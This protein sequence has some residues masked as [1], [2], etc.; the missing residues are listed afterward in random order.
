MKNALVMLRGQPF[1][2]GCDVGGS[3]W[4]TRSLSTTLDNVV[5]P[6]CKSYFPVDVISLPTVLC[7]NETLQRALRD[8]TRRKLDALGGRE[9]GFEPAPHANQAASMLAVAKK[10]M[11]HAAEY[12][13]FVVLRFDVRV[14]T[15]LTR[16]RCRLA[17]AVCFSDGCGNPN[18]PG[19]VNE[20]WLTVPARHAARVG[21]LILAGAK[22]WDGRATC[23]TA[24]P[25]CFANA[26][27]ERERG[28]PPP[29]PY[30]FSGHA[31]F[32]ELRRM[33]PGGADEA[34][35]ELGT[36][37]PPPPK[38]AHMSYGWSSHYQMFRSKGRRVR[39]A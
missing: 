1:R 22:G 9:I 17:D 29:S 39:V 35:L 13:V 11:L 38:S 28:E 24:R 26:E 8:A 2:V 36:C 7:A 5:A 37:V 15:P 33:Y 3:F 16:W 34:P 30:L 14:Q 10:L 20:M 18:W 31:C 25:G 19:C 6:L 4:Q 21:R 32:D 23:R 27:C 12:S